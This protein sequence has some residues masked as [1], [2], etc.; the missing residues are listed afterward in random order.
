[1]FTTIYCRNNPT[2]CGYFPQRIMEIFMFPIS[3]FQGGMNLACVYTEDD[4][5]CEGGDGGMMEREGNLNQ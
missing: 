1:M 5:D 4:G 2:R 3:S